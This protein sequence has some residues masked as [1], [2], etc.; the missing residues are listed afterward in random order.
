M[1]TVLMDGKRCSW[2]G[3]GRVHMLM[4]SRDN[5]KP[6][7]RVKVHAFQAQGRPITNEDV[8]KIQHAL[9]KSRT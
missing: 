8:S 7:R 2:M 9:I 1:S 4:S 3:S 5:E 6:R